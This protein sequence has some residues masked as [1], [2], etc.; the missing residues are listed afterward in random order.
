MGKYVKRNSFLDGTKLKYLNV[1]LNYIKNYLF[2]AVVSMPYNVKLDPVESI[3]SIK[4]F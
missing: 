4:I 1:T 2:S 3:F